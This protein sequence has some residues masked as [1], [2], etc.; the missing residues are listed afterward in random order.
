MRLVSRPF[1]SAVLAPLEPAAEGGFA[2]F[3]PF[4]NLVDKGLRKAEGH[5]SSVI[6]HRSSVIGHRSS[7]LD[8]RATAAPTSPRCADVAHGCRQPQRGTVEARHGRDRPRAG[9]Q[10]DRVAPILHPDGPRGLSRQARQPGAGP[11]ADRRRRP[12]CHGGPAA[13]GRCADPSGHRRDRRD[14]WQGHRWRRREARPRASPR[15]PGPIHGSSC[16]RSRSGLGAW[17]HSGSGAHPGRS[18]TLSGR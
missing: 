5:R 7:V 16:R 10:P 17:R 6:G 4:S 13:P 14:P 15:A 8:R 18:G 3:L 2:A 12:P 1:R 11:V 9:G